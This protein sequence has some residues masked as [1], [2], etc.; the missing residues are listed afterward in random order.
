MLPSGT[1]TVGES[2]FEGDTSIAAAVIPSGCRSIGK[3]A[4]RN[5]TNLESIHIPADCAIEEGAFDGCGSVN[6]YSTAD[7]PAAE[8]CRTHPDCTLIAQ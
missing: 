2:A 5:C 8:Y 3:W 4:F 1:L 7:S 6:V